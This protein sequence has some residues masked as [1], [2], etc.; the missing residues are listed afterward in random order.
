MRLQTA[1]AIY[2]NGRLVFASPELIPSNGAEVVVTY[3]GESQ[4]EG[5]PQDDPIQALR[6]RGKGER[7]NERLLRSRRADR[8]VDKRRVRNLRS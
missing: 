4:E 8:E 3:L 7:L 5:A 6:G 1:R 2:G